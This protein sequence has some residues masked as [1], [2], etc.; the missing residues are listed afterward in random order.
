MY[1]QARSDAIPKVS[2]QET[3]AKPKSTFMYTCE[4][5]RNVD[6]LETITTI[7]DAFTNE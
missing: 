6:Q 4:T 1:R 7:K 2:N 5:L 3:S